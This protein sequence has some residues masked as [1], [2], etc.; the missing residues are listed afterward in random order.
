MDYKGRACGGV[1]DGNELKH[2]GN[3]VKIQ[4][5][6]KNP[7]DPLPDKSNIL[8]ATYAWDSNAY[9]GNEYAARVCV[10]RGGGGACGTWVRVVGGSCIAY[11]YPCVHR[12]RAQVL[13]RLNKLFLEWRPR[14]RMLLSHRR[15]SEPRH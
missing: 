3:G 7:A 1:A 14:S 8:V 15:A 11:S 13:V 6:Q 5:S 9:P 10:Y 4:F 12:A 2:N